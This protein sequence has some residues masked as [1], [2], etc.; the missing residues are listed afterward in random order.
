MLKL[1]N[2]L[3]NINYFFFLNR[4]FANVGLSLLGELAQPAFKPWN[5]N[6]V[7]QTLYNDIEQQQPFDIVLECL[8]SAAFRYF[9]TNYYNTSIILN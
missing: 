1:F 9:L 8:H 7:S 6:D 4:T 5:T 3:Y 2:F